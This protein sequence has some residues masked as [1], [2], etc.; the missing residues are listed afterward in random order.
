MTKSALRRVAVIATQLS[1]VEPQSLGVGIQR[2][3]KS[4][5]G[6]LLGTISLLSFSTSAIAGAATPQ[7]NPSLETSTTIA[8]VLQPGQLTLEGT[9]ADWAATGSTLSVFA[10]A[11]SGTP[12]VG[13][14]LTMPQLGS[15]PVSKMGA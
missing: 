7:T 14:V 11:T 15:Q 3:A 12:V 9:L 6:V 2:F 10:W 13:N 5:S 4:L 1:S 8:A